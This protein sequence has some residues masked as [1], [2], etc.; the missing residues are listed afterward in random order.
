LRLRIGIDVGGT[1]T[2]AVIL[3]ENNKIMSVAK[4]DTTQDVTSGI[5]NA[6]E[7]VLSNVDITAKMSIRAVMFGTTHFTNAIVERRN[8]ARVGILR[9][10]KP[11][12]EGIKPMASLPNDLVNA[13]GGIWEIVSGGHE[14]DGREIWKFDEMAVGDAAKSFKQ[15][16]VESVAIVSV[17]SPVNPSHE[18]KAAKIVTEILGETIPIT[19]S[20]KIGSLGL[21]ERENGS[22]LNAALSKV[23]P[24]VIDALE[25]A[26]N[27][28]GLN[29]VKLY[30]TQNDGT[31]MTLDYA[32][33]YP[34]KTLACGP[35]NSMRG[36]AFLTGVKDG[37]VIDI[38]GT[39]AL[40]G[41]ISHGFPRESTVAV[42]IGGVRTNFRM[43]DL[44]A[45]SC[46]GGTIVKI[47]DSKIELGPESLGFRITSDSIAWGGKILTTTDVILGLGEAIIDD[48][49]CKPER[50]TQI[51]SIEKLRMAYNKI[52]ETLENAIDKMKT[53]IDPVPV[54][55]VGGGGIIVSKKD[56]SRFKGVSKVLRPE[57]F[58][59]ANAIGA[60]IAQVG[61]ETDRVF[62]LDKMSR[63]DAI[64]SA[65]QTASEEAIAAGA[66]S[67][68][69]EVV[70]LEE[71]PLSYLPGNAIRIRCKVV[72]KLGF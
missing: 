51:V 8:L 40:I 26:V 21:L 14:F 58:Q 63:N 24:L 39:T 11:A 53:S 15:M 62:D 9:I 19:L 37:I 6:L 17:F 64:N 46:G 31:L 65:I 41:V 32:K 38:G 18:E 13:I 30:L 10:G 35:T 68:T 54:I 33:K 22:I 61:G 60:A 1:H 42:E 20:Y 45:V 59:F 47:L 55:L 2:D 52:L 23:A 67:K 36:A 27:K 70:D 48:P 5:Y 34:V 50:V 16:D 12:T 66:D 28:V 7:S 49:A 57:Y 29:N 71:I 56:Y 25:R 43:P 72:G 4:V 44:L 3:D 69:L